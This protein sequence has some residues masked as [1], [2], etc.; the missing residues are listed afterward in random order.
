MKDRNQH[1]ESIG[2]IGGADGPTRI[3]VGGKRKKFSLKT[4]IRNFIFYHKRKAVSKKIVAAP[5]TLDEMILYAK[6]IYGATAVPHRSE[7]S[8]TASRIYEIKTDRACLAI[9]ID[10]TRDT[11]GVS[12]SG[13]KKAMKHVRRIV[14]DLYLYYGVNEHDILNQT[15]RYVSLVGVLCF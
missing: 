2:I 9:E 14:K 5:H 4:R 12:F 13:N 7:K 6:N 8:P 1:A 15:E 3:F 11:F 10:D